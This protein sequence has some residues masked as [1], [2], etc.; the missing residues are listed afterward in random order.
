MK[1][2]VLLIILGLAFCLTQVTLSIYF[3]ERLNDGDVWD[4][5]FIAKDATYDTM[6]F[7]FSLLV[8]WSYK[9]HE[10]PG[11][12]ALC[13]FL[14]IVTGGSFIDKVIFGINQYLRSDILLIAMGVVLS[15]IKY[16]KWKTLKAG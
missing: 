12:K 11:A 4:R 10:N 15:V 8:F 13:V 6:F 2:I 14:V 16:R 7:V 5:Y 9:V 1:N 3:P